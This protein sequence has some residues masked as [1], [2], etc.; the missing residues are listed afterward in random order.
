MVRLDGDGLA[1]VDA[2]AKLY[3]VARDTNPV[4]YSYITPDIYAD[5]NRGYRFDVLGAGV[6]YASTHS[7]GAYTETVQGY[8]LTAATAAACAK[9]HPGLMAAGSI[10]A[11][12]R[13]HRR[14]VAFS[15]PG[16]LPFVDVDA[17]ETHTALTR[18]LAA[19][20]NSPTPF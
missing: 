7:E 4:G 13:T 1:V 19:E 8:R 16:A 10:P 15:L 9:A 20:L 6:L 11:D 18:H 14:L 17:T 5:D 12:W 3:R 2:P